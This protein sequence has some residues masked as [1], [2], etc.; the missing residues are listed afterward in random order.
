[1][2]IIIQVMQVGNGVVLPQPI[3]FIETTVAP[4]VFIPTQ[5]QVTHFFNQLAKHSHVTIIIIILC[6]VHTT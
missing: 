4:S 1:M 5:K 6:A 3:Y 2:P